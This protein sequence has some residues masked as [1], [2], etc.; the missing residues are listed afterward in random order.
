MTATNGT[1]TCYPKLAT[2]NYEILRA[3]VLGDINRASE[4]TL[5]MRNGMI[6]WFHALQKRSYF[7]EEIYKENLPGLTEPDVDMSEGGLVAILADSILKTTT[8]DLRR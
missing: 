6:V 3:N 2:R 8:A 1:D 4:F 5:F 7:R